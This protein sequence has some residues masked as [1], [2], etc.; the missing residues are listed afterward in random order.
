MVGGGGA[1]LE[2]DS[3][4]LMSPSAE[5]KDLICLSAGKTCNWLRGVRSVLVCATKW[6]FGTPTAIPEQRC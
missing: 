1:L 3:R 2:F 6:E 4:S 5:I